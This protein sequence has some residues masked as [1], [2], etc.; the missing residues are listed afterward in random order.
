MQIDGSPHAWFEARG[1]GCT[2]LI[3]VDIA[4]AFAP[5][6]ITD[7]NQRFAFQPRSDHDAH[8]PLAFSQ[9][10]LD[11]IFSLQETRTVSKN[12]SIQYNKVIYQIQSNR[13][14]Y[15]LRR[16]QVTVVVSPLEQI[17]ILYQGKPLHYT[18][19][20]QQPRQAEIIPT[21]QLNAHLD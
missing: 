21:K 2:C 12:L 10:E 16:A 15:A 13:P 20:H 6:F 17:S 7:Y 4:N 5:A 8:R 14:S 18:I 3:V 9:Q 19:F 11:Q 1:P